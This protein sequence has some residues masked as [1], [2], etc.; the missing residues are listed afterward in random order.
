M[1]FCPNCKS[2][3]RKG[4]TECYDCQIDLVDELVDD[5]RLAELKKQGYDIFEDW[6]AIKTF[7]Q[8][9]QAQQLVDLF[10]YNGIHSQILSQADSMF[11]L[12]GELSIVR[13]MVQLENFDKALEVLKEQEE[14]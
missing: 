11:K 12:P 10:D 8:N 6:I 1:P 13:V 3:Y 4:F 2:E 5:K 7:D 9:Y 14:N